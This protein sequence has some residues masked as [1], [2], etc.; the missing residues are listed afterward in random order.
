MKRHARHGFTLVE[1]LVV[2]GIIAVLIAILMPALAAARR[3][4]YATQCASN[5]RQIGLGMAMYVNENGQRYPYAGWD[6]DGWNSANRRVWCWDEL[7]SPYLSIKMTQA[8]M[9]GDGTSD[10]IPAAI[11]LF[12]CPS[13]PIA[14]NEGGTPETYALNAAIGGKWWGP[15]PA[16][17]PFSAK[18]SDVVDASG[19]L[20]V[21][22]CPVGNGFGRVEGSNCG[23]PADQSYII[24]GNPFLDNTIPI[25]TPDVGL[26]PQETMN[27]LFCDGHVQRLFPLE[28]DTRT[29]P[30]GAMQGTF[31]GYWWNFVTVPDLAGNLGSGFNYYGTAAG[32]W[33]LDPND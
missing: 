10:V 4:A 14:A 6:Q 30:S 23:E 8:E 26:H 5:M 9:D 29:Y 27:Y 17:P 13:D 7:I 2:I 24:A 15:S 11:A 20:L 31:N 16:P 12:V 25:G 18:T 3:S 32:M 22:E 33:S 21:V 1:L 19:T 28:T